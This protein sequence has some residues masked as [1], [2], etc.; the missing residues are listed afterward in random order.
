VIGLRLDDRSGTK[1]SFVNDLRTRTTAFFAAPATLTELAVCRIAWCA[2]CLMHLSLSGLA[3]RIDTLATTLPVFEPS[4]LLSL[5]SLPF[6]GPHALTAHELHAILYATQALGVLALAGFGTRVALPLFAIG[7]LLLQSWVTSYGYSFHDIGLMQWGLLLLAFSRCGE[8]LSIDGWI[9]RRAGRARVLSEPI[10]G[11][12]RPMRTM[13][14]L[15]ALA[16]LSAGATKILRDPTAWFSGYTLQYYVSFHALRSQS[17]A[18][19]WL[20]KH[21]TLVT[22][23]AWGVVLFETSF[24]L[25]LWWRSRAWIWVIGSILVHASAYLFMGV[26]FPSF[27]VLC[28]TVL[29][30]RLRSAHAAAR[31]RETDSH[32][33]A[34][35]AGATKS[36]CV[37]ARTKRPT[38]AREIV[39]G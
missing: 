32:A 1:A 29:P 25:S 10:E 34:T 15:L 18:G 3:T 14:V 17:A 5:L 35:R 6:G 7:A 37:P 26:L 20:M 12:A 2:V 30:W 28:A 38:G 23:V 27:P 33:A 8:A 4:L 11:A 31:E 36:V 19:L 13:H 16:Y 21:H 9:A 39:R 22:A 24:I